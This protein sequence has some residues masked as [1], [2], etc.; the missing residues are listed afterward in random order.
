[1][2]KPK[3]V[4]VIA[5]NNCKPSLHTSHFTL[6]KIMIGI[7][8]SGV[9]GLTVIKELKKQLP[10]LSFIYLGDNAR[11][12]YGTRSQQIV[13]KYSQEDV[14]FLIEKG[15]KEIII[16][17]NTASAF[18]GEYLR[19]K[20]DLPIFEVITPAAVAAIKVTKGRIGVIGTRG[21]IN[22]QA[23]EKVILNLNRDVKVF[24]QACPLFVPLVEENHVSRRETKMIVRGYLSPLKV[25]SI[26]TL[27]LGCTHY[28]LLCRVI[29]D[30][31][32][33]KIKLINPAEAVVAA[34][35]EH[36]KDNDRLDWSGQEEYFA[37]DTDSRFQEIGSRWLGKL[38]EVK[39][40]EL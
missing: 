25:K 30:K 33:R 31:I 34:L 37:T 36:V 4:A 15:A 16:A 2:A 13:Q 12:P 35:S 26:D 9:G 39:K 32:G 11:T 23:H 18:A 19:S 22:S 21:T 10:G 14:D 3:G 17:C 8:D 1:M 38:I 20:Y 28:P 5:I 29:Q 7:F 24:G 6:N 27:I 40:A